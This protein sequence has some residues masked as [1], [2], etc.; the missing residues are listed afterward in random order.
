MADMDD[1]LRAICGDIA[2][3]QRY[4]AGPKRI[5]D[6]VNDLMA[7]RGYA[8]VQSSA[9]CAE[10]WRIAGRAVEAESVSATD[11][12]GVGVRVPCGDDDDMVSR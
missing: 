8:Q 12:G 3:R 10:A 9:A 5:A 4:R 2:S 7:R 1:D 6:V 11:G